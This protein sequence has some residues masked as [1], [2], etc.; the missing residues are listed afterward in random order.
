MAKKR[1]KYRPRRL[2][3]GKPGREK[4]DRVRAPGG[5]SLKVCVK[6]GRYGFSAWLYSRDGT[7]TLPLSTG[8]ARTIKSA[9]SAA[10]QSY[11]RASR[12]R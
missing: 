12:R 7:K 6:E 5:G 8:R 11:R 3:T 10:K 4:C 2:R 1:S 9:L